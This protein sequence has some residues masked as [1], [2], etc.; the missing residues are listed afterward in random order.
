MNSRVLNRHDRRTLLS[1]ARKRHPTFH[2]LQI[3]KEL[4]KKQDA[5]RG[6]PAKPA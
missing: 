1:I 2:Q 5:L 3:V 4:G 6:N